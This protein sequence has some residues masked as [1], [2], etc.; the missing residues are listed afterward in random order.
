MQTEDLFATGTIEVCAL[1]FVRGRSIMNSYLI[2]DEAQNANST[3]I[4]DV[5]TRAGE[6]TS[7]VLAGDPK[8][9][10][11]NLDSHNNGLVYAASKMKGSPMCGIIKFPPQSSVR[12]SLAKEATERM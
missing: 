8:Q 4:R 1:S 5:I 12:S 9:I 6:A 3:L 7:V 2:C 11:V 10:D